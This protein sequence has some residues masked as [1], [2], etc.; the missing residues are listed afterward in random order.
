MIM[1][2]VRN[3][4]KGLVIVG[5]IAILIFIIL[6]I[7]RIYQIDSCI[8]KGGKW[9]YDLNKCECFY[10]I[11]TNRIADYYWISVFDTIKNQEYLKRGK[12]LDSIS[13]SPNELINILN[14]RP[15]KCK[16]EY[17]NI[18]EDTLKIRILDDEYL[19]EQMGT[20]GVDCYMAETIFTLTENDLIKF[21]RF[22][23]DYGTHAGPG[24]YSRKDYERM[25]NK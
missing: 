16:I 8:D 2:N 7:Y 19:T 18:D 20:S 11:D 23:M 25:L 5:I 9:N 17:V 15:S 24:L 10:T 12:M 14:F 4:K 21:I 6:K 13:K 1:I 3:I 22:E